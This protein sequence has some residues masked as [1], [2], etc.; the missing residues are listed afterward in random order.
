MAPQA[1]RAKFPLFSPAVTGI[2]AGLIKPMKKIIAIACIA[3]AAAPLLA[4]GP[5]DNIAENVRRIPAP[6]IEVPAQDRADLEKGIAALGDA[7]AKLKQTYAKKPDM[8]D[9]LPDIEI[10]HR[11]V[12][13]ALTYN[14]FFKANEI[15]VAKGLLEDG[16]ARANALAEGK[17]PW[18]TQKG[19]VVRGY[20]SKIDHS[21]QPYGLVIPETWQPGSATKHRFDTWFH[22]RGE[23]LSEV[24]FIDQRQRSVGQFAPADTFV[25]HPYGRY[26][27]ANKF[28]GEID[29]LEALDHA[30]KYYPMDENRIV[31]RG[32]SMG[33]AACWQFAVHYAGRW[34]AASPG[35]GFSETADFLKVFQGEDVGSTSWYEKK[36]WHMYD[37]TDWA[38]NLFHC[39]TIG[40]SGEIDRQKQAADMMEK[41]LASEGIDMIHLIGPD[42]AHKIHPDSAIEIERRLASITRQPRDIVPSKVR[43]TTWTLRY[44]DMLWV[45]VDAMKEHWERARVEAEIGSDNFVSVDTS[46]VEALTLN[47][48]AGDCP[49]DNTE[50]VNLVV[51]NIHIAN[52]P[53]VFS[54]RSWTVHLRRNADKAWQVVDSAKAE[55]LHKRHGL[56]GPIDDAFMD[57]FVMVRPTGKALNEPVGKW[58]NGEMDHAIEH[59]RRQFRGEARVKDDK[60]I[61]DEDIA[62]AN[63]VLWGDPSSNRILAKIIDALPIQWTAKGLVAN[64]KTFDAT[65]SAAVMIF[66]NPLNPERYVVLNSGFTFREYDYLNNA[67]QVSKLPDWAVIDIT[68]P[69][70]S[71]LPGG[72]ADAGFFDED[73]AWKATPKP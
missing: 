16:M 71:R 40:Y 25:L 7:I 50:P 2:V 30:K 24:N 22:G 57:S 6:G 29:L 32:F 10:Y 59:W 52:T 49:L 1:R 70:T 23:T 28:A 14:E 53:Q 36:L 26:S 39:P 73:W 38:V 20:R 66:P 56:Q 62:G 12:W 37:C 63:L 3:L 67:R 11:A 31:V 45:T 61:S 55:G 44:N 33:G 64:G 54:D 60:D 35:A 65:K 46:N 58:V 47:M 18:L 15:K 41:A 21:V 27:N 8:L 68:Q 19:L 5:T 72:I 51:D 13:S 34:C 43:F 4:D 17:A 42:T 9:L 69:M 48:E